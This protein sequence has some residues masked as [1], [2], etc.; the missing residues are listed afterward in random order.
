MELTRGGGAE[1][2]LNHVVKNIYIHRYYT[3]TNLMT[4]NFR[5]QLEDNIDRGR[6]N[7]VEAAPVRPGERVTVVAL[8]P[9]YDRRT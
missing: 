3:A 4:T 5:T 2:N 9:G 7:T 8:Y 6:R 1:P